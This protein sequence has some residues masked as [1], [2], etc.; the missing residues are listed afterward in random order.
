[1]IKQIVDDK[2]F[3]LPDIEDF[4]IVEKKEILHEDIVE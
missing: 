4:E 1:L 2:N 3:R